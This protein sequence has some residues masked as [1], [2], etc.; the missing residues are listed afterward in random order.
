M[1]S[2]ANPSPIPRDPLAALLDG[3]ADGFC[4][5][6]HV[7][8]YLYV[9]AEAVRILGRPRDELLHQAALSTFPDD[10][11]NDVAHSA[12]RRAFEQRVPVEFRLDCARLSESFECR[13]VP[14]PDGVSLHFRRVP[15]SYRERHDD[16][17]TSAELLTA[18]GEAAP[19]FVWVTNA[20]GDVL[21]VNRR[22]I[23]Y[24]GLTAEQTDRR[25]YVK[26]IHPVDLPRF[27]NDVEYAQRAGSA[28][29]GE[30]RYRRHD[31]EY[32]WFWVRSTPLKDVDGNLHRRVGVAVDI[33]DRRAAEQARKDA[34]QALRDSEAKYRTL[35]DAVGSL[36]WM[37]D[38]EGRLRFYNR[39]WDEFLAGDASAILE[40]GWK[41]LVH[42]DDLPTVIRER[43]AALAEGREYAM[44]HRLRRHDGQYR[45]H[46]TRIV[47]HKD[48]DGKIV[49]WFGTAADIHDLKMA[50]EAV[51]HAKADAEHANK[52]KDQFLAVLSHELR[53]P[54]TPVVM[55]VAAMEME[56]T[57]SPQMREDL[58]MIRRNIELETKLIDDLLDVTRIAN[59]KLRLQPRAADVHALLKNVLEMLRADVNDKEIR[60]RGD[61]AAADPRIFGDPARLQ[62]VFWN[63]IKNA[64]KF[65]PKHGTVTIRSWNEGERLVCVEVLDTG[66]GIEPSVLPRIFNA[67]DQGEQ[68]ITRQFGGLGLG[69]A[70]SKAL[71]ELH[72]G[73]IRVD[74][75][76]KGK[77]ARFTVELPIRAPVERMVDQIQ[78]MGPSAGAGPRPRILLV[79]DHLDTQRTLC[80]L[81]E[82]RGFE[83]L[84]AGSV[85]AALA[86]LAA[87]PVDLI[88]SDIG[89]PDATGYELM[90][91]VRASYEIPG[92]AVSGFGM[93]GDLKSS[94][95]AGFAAHLTK[96]VDMQHLDSTI[97]SLLRVP[98]TQ[99]PAAS[100]PA[101]R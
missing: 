21:Y 37:S 81:L 74:S 86:T 19:D 12:V 13:A 27:L 79:E 51:L 57:L 8:R 62:Q 38:A 69:L 93:D 42:P 78:P 45:W 89:L 4:A 59:G 34:E 11:D 20:V 60:T 63:L 100:A 50:E 29:E 70:I 14:S 17:R 101:V 55:T 41:D 82:E 18:I 87:A 73:T 23:E 76:G 85:A 1:T 43:T 30:F 44:E 77:G 71:T 39:R 2:N 53:T 95:D 28:I 88:L 68:T 67:F 10:D 36:M 31:G 75:E 61:F 7:A 94:Q 80:R 72:G 52:A 26:T 3:S 49:N 91:K 6:D 33:D 64:I 92:I 66:A 32:R 40:L 99:S 47:P 15:G 58:A 48:A 22:W 97:R 98:A 25:G 90:R 5:L 96:P 24:T 84:V 9:N 65:T 56:R 16:M 83:M 54:L 35:T 46:L